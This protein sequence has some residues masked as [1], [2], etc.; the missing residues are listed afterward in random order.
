MSKSATRAKKSKISDAKT[1]ITFVGDPVLRQKAKPIKDI[2]AAQPLVRTMAKKLRAIQGAGLAAPQVGKSL[3]LFVVEVRRN[4]LFPRRPESGLFVV[5]NPRIVA[6]SRSLAHGWEACFSIPGY[7]GEV[8]RHESITMTY[9]D[10]TG[11][12]KRQTFHGYLARV[13][14]HEY[15]HI[16]G[17]VYIDRMKDMRT[18]STV[19]NWGKFHL[20]T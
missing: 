20:D 10:A 13:M 3:R 9:S 14:Q 15:D 1:G 17:H 16:E 12:Q 8:P 18:F 6:R 19:E 4:D 7:I 2:R 11:T 5:I